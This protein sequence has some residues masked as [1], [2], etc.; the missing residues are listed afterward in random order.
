[1]KNKSFAIFLAIFLPFGTLANT[2]SVGKGKDFNTIKSALNASNNGDTI[3]IYN[4]LY[5]EGALEIEKKICIIGI[6]LP[7]ISG[8]K[9]FEVLNIKADSV[10]VE[11]LRIVDVGI[12]YLKDLAAIRVSQSHHVTI[13]GNRIENAF[14]GIYLAKSH[15]AEITYNEIHGQAKSEHNSGNAIHLWSCNNAMIRSNSVSNHRDGIYLEFVENS[16]VM[17]NLSEKNLRYGLHFMFSNHDEYNHNIFRY[18]GAGVAVM[19]SR[20][21]DMCHNTFSNNWGPSAYGLLLKEIFDG[22]IENNIFHT[23][24]TAIHAEG[25]SRTKINYNNFQENGW[26]LNISGSNLKNEITANNF[27][28]NTFDII[29]HTRDL[30]TSYDHNYWSE[31]S[32][33]DLDKDQIGDVPHRPITLFTYIIEQVPESIVLL[34]SP[35]VDLMS[36]AEKISPIFTP[37]NVID[38]TPSTKKFYVKID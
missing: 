36:V 3:L 19:F 15:N 26:A 4:G 30:T 11:G 24:S 37:K 31:Y 13:T 32:G 22:N 20:F 33:Y 9:K 29:G 8:S 34:R 12:S 7:R 14:F 23:N 1:M 35:F 17:N 25:V 28:N 16:F 27:L 10:R 21:I 38:N 2:I 18:N 5:A 6:N